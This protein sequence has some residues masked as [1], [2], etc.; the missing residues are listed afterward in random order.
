MSRVRRRQAFVLGFLVALVLVFATPH[1]AAATPKP[2]GVN[3]NGEWK[4]A[5]G[6]A[7]VAPLTE[8]VEDARASPARSGCA[9]AC[10]P[11]YDS[12]C[13]LARLPPT[14]A[15]V[16][17]YNSSSNTDDPAG[18]VSR[19]RRVSSGSEVRGVAPRGVPP[20]R[21]S[22]LDDFSKLGDE[23]AAWRR[24]GAS[25]EFIAREANA[26][27]R[28]LGMK[29]KDLTPEPLR[30]QIRERNLGRYGDEWGPT[31]DFLRRE[32]KTWEEIIESS[33]RPGGKDLGF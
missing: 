29:Y 5:T 11:S 6:S 30:S 18:H 27:R 9:Y 16:Y 17:G 19:A 7:N 3:A 1:T 25:P 22:Y 33:L 8:G 32:G 14:E 4:S 23:V 21:Q 26:N 31:I 12:C 24:A 2:A 13:D 20:L 28:A 15:Y 10:T